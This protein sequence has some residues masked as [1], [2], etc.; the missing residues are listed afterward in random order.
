MTRTRARRLGA[1]LVA[2]GL[3]ATMA[4]FA[5]PPATAQVDVSEALFSGYS[6]GTV[7]HADALNPS[8]T[9]RV[10]DAEVAFSAAGVNSDGLGP[11]ISN[12]MQRLTIPAN[13]GKNSYGQAKAVEAALADDPATDGQVVLPAKV[14][15]AA[16]PN[17][18]P[19]TRNIVAVPGDPA[20]YIS[21]GD[22]MAQAKWSDNA[23]ILGQDTSTGTAQVANAQLLDLVDTGAGATPELEAP[24]LAADI[25][26]RNVSDTRSRTKI[27]PQMSE[28][29]ATAPNGTVVGPNFGLMSQ[30]RMTIAPVRLN[31]PPDTNVTNDILIEVLGEWVLTVV[32]TGIPGQAW[33]H[34]GPGAVENATPVL[35]IGTQTLNAQQVFG[36][37]GFT[38][39]PI[40][41][42]V[43][44]A[45]AEDPRAIGG[46]ATTTPVISADGTSVAAAV[47]VVRLQVAEPQGVDIRI[48]HMEAKATVPAGG[49]VCPIPVTKDADPREITGPGTFLYNIDVFNT[50]SACPLEEVVVT[51]VMDTVSG[52]PIYAF[53]PDD[54]RNDPANPVISGGGKTATIN[55]GTIAPGATKRIVLVVSATGGSGLIENTVDVDGVLACPANPAFGEAAVR[56]PLSGTFAVQLPRVDI[57]RVL[58]RTGGPLLLPVGMALLTAAA[59]VRR[60]RRRAG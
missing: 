6:T 44:I 40:P 43:S 7:I 48:G 2:S 41:G 27:V 32:A 51:D 55:V 45:I 49:I 23:C 3:V 4:T 30:T 33:V 20:A 1:A 17:E 29:T 10:L 38:L 21:A 52:N 53:A 35:T 12:E 25:A 11:A 34:Y 60:V 5:P 54:P 13:S 39:D 31:L 56:V 9:T 26:G 47:D 18:G 36:Q 14:E 57:S 58:P 28:P 24:L 37:A 8:A 42:V 16:P 59:V 19:V 50:H 46:L 22:I 15:A